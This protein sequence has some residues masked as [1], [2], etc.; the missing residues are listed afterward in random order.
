MVGEK[1]EKEAAEEEVKVLLKVTW[2]FFLPQFI[3]QCRVVV[4]LEL[5]ERGEERKMG[6]QRDL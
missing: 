3:G 1:K 4:V 5:L 6:L 2:L